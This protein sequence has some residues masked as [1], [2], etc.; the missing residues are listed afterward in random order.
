MDESQTQPSPIIDLEPDECWALAAGQPVGR[1]AWTGPQG[2]TVVPVN[3]VVTGRRVHIRTTAYSALARE[4][5]DSPV[6]F[7]V[8]QFDAAHRSGWSVLMRGRAHLHY[9][10][11]DGSDEPDVWP[12]GIRGLQVALEVDEVTGRRVG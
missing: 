2:P 8:D 1:L 3:F 7:E 5:D 4:C 10:V 11:S 6:A 9:G 12:T